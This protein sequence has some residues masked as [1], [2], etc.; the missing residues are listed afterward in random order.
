LS[1]IWDKPELSRKQRK[2]FLR[3]LIDKVTLH[4]EQCDSLSMRI[5]GKGGD[6]TTTSLN[7][8]VGS[9]KELSSSKETENQIIIISQ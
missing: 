4:R 1:T 7:I 9:F 6:T 3:C 2:K 8:T 5:V